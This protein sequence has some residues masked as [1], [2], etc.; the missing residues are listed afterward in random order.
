MMAAQETANWVVRSRLEAMRLSIRNLGKIREADIVIN[1][2]TVIAAPND[3]GKSTI[4][5]AAFALFESFE[6]FHQRVHDDLI[7]PIRRILRSTGADRNMTER[8]SSS[9]FRFSEVG[10]MVMSEQLVAADALIDEQTLLAFLQSIVATEQEDVYDEPPFAF[11]DTGYSWRLLVRAAGDM[12][13]WLAG[14]SDTAI[15][16]RQ[17]LLRAYRD[18]HAVSD[19]ERAVELANRTFNTVFNQQIAGRFPP[20]AK[21]SGGN[22]SL[23]QTVVR[24]S[25]ER[26]EHGEQDREAIFVKDRCVQAAP[27]TDEYRHVSIVDD[28]NIIEQFDVD[29]LSSSSATGDYRQELLNTVAAALNREHESLSANLTETILAKRDIA[30]VMELIEASF[31]G[32]V[33]QG[34]HG[35]VMV[36]DGVNESIAIGN[37]SLGSKAIMLLRFLIEHTI[38]KSGDMLVLDEPEIHLHPE[39]QI[40]YAHTLVLIAKR[41]G[42]RMIVTTHSP[43]FLKALAAYSGVEDFAESMRY[44]TSDTNDDGSNTFREVPDDEVG[45]LYAAMAQPLRTIDDDVLASLQSGR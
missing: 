36:K 25:T 34:D 19:T 44:Y 33:E 37:A 28:P 18:H 26:H 27:A 11:A 2:V 4:G 43:Y 20:P 16:C 23:T 21:E 3:T 39:W 40:T 42:I 1:G 7:S 32:H 45:H 13:H 41:L 5:K 29:V 22:G 8:N 38:V 35:P 24:L 6:D 12:A 17:R 31:S 9:G 14:D 10:S 30:A 15:E